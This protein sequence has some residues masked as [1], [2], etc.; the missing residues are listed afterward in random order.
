MAGE[1][2]QVGDQVMDGG[3]T[4]KLALRLEALNDLHPSSDRLVRIFGLVVQAL[5]PVMVDVGHEFPSSGR[6]GAKLVIDQ[7][8]RRMTLFFRSFF[9]RRLAALVSRRLCTRTSSTKPS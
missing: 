7:H 3:E 4:L 9:I 5:V 1:V 8:P 2:E 6:V